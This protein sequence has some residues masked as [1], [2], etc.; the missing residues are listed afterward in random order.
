MLND[1]NDKLKRIT[2][3]FITD[4]EESGFDELSTDSMILVI[5]VTR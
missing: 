4:K 5:A 3:S 1:Y 2:V